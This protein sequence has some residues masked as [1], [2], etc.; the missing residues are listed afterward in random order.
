MCFSVGDVK[1]YEKT[2]FDNF[3]YY[4][5]SSNV[6][7]IQVGAFV[8][9]KVLPYVLKIKVIVSKLGLIL[10]LDLSLFSSFIYEQTKLIL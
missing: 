7:R 8:S 5:F 4:K 6:S 3:G 1:I 10:L 9:K 2:G